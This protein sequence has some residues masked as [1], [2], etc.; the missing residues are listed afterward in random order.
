MSTVRILY[1]TNSPNISGDNNEITIAH[2]HVSAIKDETCESSKAKDK[3]T[4]L[5]NQNLNHLKVCMSFFRTLA[6]KSKDPI[7]A[8]HAAAAYTEDLE[9]V[10][11]FAQLSTKVYLSG[12]GKY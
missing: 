2:N 8:A 9:R 11:E 10:G 5:I 7:Q 6:D 1:E 4:N 3:L 12:R